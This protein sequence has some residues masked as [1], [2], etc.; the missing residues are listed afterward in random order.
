MHMLAVG[1]SPLLPLFRKNPLTIRFVLLG[2]HQQLV[3]DSRDARIY[4]QAARI[5]KCSKAR[6]QELLSQAPGPGFPHHH[7]QLPGRA[8]MGHTAQQQQ[9]LRVCA[10][11][12]THVEASCPEGPPPGALTEKTRAVHKGSEVRRFNNTYHPV[13]ETEK[14]RRGNRTVLE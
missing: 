2:R 9:H 6:T 13:R 12:P 11:N 8:A 14:S 4:A 10:P 1:N 3:T 7:H 5:C